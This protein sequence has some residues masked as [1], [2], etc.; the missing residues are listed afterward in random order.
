MTDLDDEERAAVQDDE[1]LCRLCQAKILEKAKLCPTCGCY[2]NRWLNGLRHSSLIGASIAVIISAA[3][4]FLNQLSQMRQRSSVSWAAIK[5]DTSIT[6]ANTGD[7]T[8]F[9]DELELQIPDFGFAIVEDLSLGIEEGKVVTAPLKFQHLSALATPYTIKEWEAQRA[10]GKADLLLRDAIFFNEDSLHLAQ[11]ISNQGSEMPILH[12]EGCIHYFATI[13]SKKGKVCQSLVAIPF[14]VKDPTTD[15]EST[16][17]N[18][19]TPAPQQ[20]SP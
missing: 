11:W 9:A 3:P 6:I 18:T 13:A 10:V 20:T 2:Q 7:G 19:L 1:K 5:S 16:P 4:F 15:E 8:I 12:G 17:P 14:K